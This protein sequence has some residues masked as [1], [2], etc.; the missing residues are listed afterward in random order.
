[1][2]NILKGEKEGRNEVKVEEAWMYGQYSNF[3]IFGNI[4]IARA[5]VAA[6]A[7]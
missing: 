2:E 3:G 6:I 4:R 1:M 5:S 7:Q